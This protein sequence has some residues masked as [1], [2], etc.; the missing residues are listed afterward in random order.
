[1]FICKSD[2]R[3]YE[4][5]NTDYFALLKTIQE[6]NQ[7]PLSLIHYVSDLTDRSTP[8]Q[9]IEA[10]SPRPRPRRLLRSCHQT[11]CKLA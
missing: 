11:G 3:L 5:N 10:E 8:V 9:F 2:N 4:N 6:N 7:E 1:M